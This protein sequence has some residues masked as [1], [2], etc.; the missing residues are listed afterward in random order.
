MEIVLIK[1]FMT[2][3]LEKKPVTIHIQTQTINKIDPHLIAFCC[4]SIYLF[5]SPTKARQTLFSSYNNGI[6]KMLYDQF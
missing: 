6:P 3:R 4:C 2:V 5:F 1:D